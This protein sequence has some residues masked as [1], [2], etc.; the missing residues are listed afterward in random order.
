M[1]ETGL[2]GEGHKNKNISYGNFAATFILSPRE[3]IR[4]DELTY[5]S[6]MSHAVH[7]VTISPFKPVQ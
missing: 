1:V 3:F 2:A 7:S 6:C 4:R 5:N